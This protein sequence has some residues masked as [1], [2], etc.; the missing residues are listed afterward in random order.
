MME[1]SLKLITKF[2]EDLEVSYATQTN[3]KGAPDN[4]LK[5]FKVFVISRAFVPGE[6]I[7]R[8][9]TIRIP[10]FFA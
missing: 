9:P 8:K 2:L 5:L 3:Q 7:L 6:A 4:A 1:L 10:V